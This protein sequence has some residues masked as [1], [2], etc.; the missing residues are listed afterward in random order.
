MIDEITEEANDTV[1]EPEPVVEIEVE[2]EIDPI[3]F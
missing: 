2:P 1:S 3:E